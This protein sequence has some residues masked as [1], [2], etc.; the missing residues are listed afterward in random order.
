[1]E[2][3][4]RAK[5]ALEEAERNLETQEQEVKAAETRIEAL[6]LTVAGIPNITETNT[7]TGSWAS[8]AGTHIDFTDVFEKRSRPFSPTQAT[9]PTWEREREEVGLN[10]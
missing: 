7:P 8:T 10:M 4:L 6:K 9:Q 1:M 2:A 5:E 3:V